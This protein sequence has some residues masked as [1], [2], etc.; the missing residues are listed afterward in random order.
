ML[1]QAVSETVK[2]IES[3][4]Q[5]QFSEFHETRIIKK[6]KSVDDVISRNKL[7][8]CNYRS[9]LKSKQTNNVATMKSNISL[10]SRLYIANQKRAEDLDTFFSHEN[11]SVPPSLSKDRMLRS[12]DKSDLID[13]LINKEM[14]IQY[15]T[16]MAYSLKEL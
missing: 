13:C 10:F 9:K 12:G 1:D 3:I 14:N 2:C 11:S 8:L 4:G 16:Q 15:Q 7:P 5:A 6:N